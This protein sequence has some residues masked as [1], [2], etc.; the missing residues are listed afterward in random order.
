MW[1]STPISSDAISHLNNQRAVEFE[2]NRD[3]RHVAANDST[4]RPSGM[5]EIS[6]DQLAALVVTAARGDEEAWRELVDRFAPRVFGLIRI[7]RKKLRSRRSAPLR[8]SFGTTRK[9]GDLSLG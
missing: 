3:A 1:S 9:L 4:G 5:D 8:P 6:P 2:A 7:W